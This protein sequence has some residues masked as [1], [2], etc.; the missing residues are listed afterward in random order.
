[1]VYAILVCNC[2]IFCCTNPYKKSNEAQ[3]QFLD[4]LVL[5]TC[6][7]YMPFSTCENIWSWN[8]LLQCSHVVFPSCTTLVEEMS[9]IIITKTIQ[10]HALIRFAK[11]LW[12]PKGN[13]NT[14]AMVSITLMI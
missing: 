13:V 11:D 5:S 9:P 12:M 1:M 3:Q 10:L 8:I 14:F 6:K 7:G 2:N 4:N